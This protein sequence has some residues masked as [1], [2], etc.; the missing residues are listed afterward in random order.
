VSGTIPNVN[1][2]AIAKGASDA[3]W[4]FIRDRDISTMNAIEDGAEKAI[5]R[6]LNDHTS[7]LIIAI[8]QAAKDSL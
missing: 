2:E 8:A 3:V 5:R 4:D 7:E 6:W 1:A